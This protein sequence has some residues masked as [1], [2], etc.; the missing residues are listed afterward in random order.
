MA[1]EFK[2]KNG[3]FSEGSS[4]V[5]GSLNV[6][7][8]ITGSLQGTA[9]FATTAGSTTA[10]AGTT[11]YV[12][13]FTSGTTIGN[14]QIFDNG[15]NVGIGTTSPTYKLDV[16][17][18]TLINSSIS[19]QG[20][21][22]I[23]PLAPPPAITGY[24]LSAGSSLGVGNYY[25]F[26]T[27]VT[28]IGET[29]AGTTLIVT[30]TPGSTTVNL[31]G[32]PISSDARVTAR[33]LYRTKLGGTSDNQ[34]LLAT[35]NNNTTTTYTDSIADAS[36]TGLGLQYYKINTTSR[37]IT[38]SGI[39]SMFLD[40]N[41]TAIGR[42][43]G[44]AL[45][46]ANATAVR[47]VLVGTL[48]GQNITTGT[49]NVIVGVAGASLTSGNSNSIL[50]D[51]ALYNASTGNNN[52]AVGSQVGRYLTVGNNNV[53]VGNNAASLLNDG[54]TQFT[55]PTLGVYIG[56]N[57]R[58]SSTTETNAIVI[59][60]GALGLGSNTVVL[61]NDSIVTT[62]LKGNVG[63]G[64]T[65]P[66]ARLHV[67][68]QG[69][70]STDI[71]FRVRN[72]ANTFD[73]IRAQGNGSVFIGLG[74]GNVNTGNGNTAFGVQALFSNTTGV[75][76]TAFGNGALLANTTA[77]RN[78]AFGYDNLRNNTTGYE[79]TSIGNEALRANS[80]GYRNTADGFQALFSNTTGHS[81]T[82]NGAY[83]LQNNTTGNENTV[84]GLGALVFNTT[85]NNNIANGSN[86]GRLI[87]N[88]S[89]LTITNN[90]VFLGAGT[91][92]LADNQTNQIVIGHNAIG[93]GSNSVVL[94][95]DLITLTALKGNVGIGTTSPTARLH[96]QA[97]GALSTDIAF[98]VRNSAGTLDIIRA[99]G[100][101]SVFVGQGAGNVNTGTNNTAH[102]INALRSNTTGGNN[103][104]NGVQSLLDNTTGN[105]NTA[106]G[107][108]ALRSN[109]TGGNN[110]A[111]GASAGRYIADGITA[112]TITNNSVYLG[113]GTRAQDNNQTNQIVIGHNAIGNGSNTVTL[114]NTSIVKT[115]LRGTLNAANL[116]TSP[117]GLVTGD[118]WNNLGILTIV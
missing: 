108:F 65:S 37:H 111:N 102:G 110:T 79:N 27:Y 77:I 118:I 61:G 105:N 6:S 18:T 30:T 1:N 116:P 42:N 46:A 98:R 75:N 11:N 36:L 5:T 80:T 91:R 8:G 99:Q 60:N 47:T 22:N 53:M 103:T 71:G 87:A 20:A 70:L 32:I 113:V 106:N 73:I 78:T 2:I 90:S 15:T 63:I 109:T 57:V 89:N 31:T 96:V 114:G 17:G 107:I 25:Y 13:K 66:T 54:V 58:G 62:A 85:G 44:S 74:A 51:L 23:N 24:T 12:S 19:T 3:F 9:S 93:L 64:T 41:L 34:W 21:F 55:S 10:V 88:G 48:A 40:T 100:D 67:Q 94:G 76:N 29:S 33:K 104:A 39:Q 43:A 26:A 86:A 45:I 56:A 16:H 101:G 35:I 4:N 14:S 49:A 59:G 115:I 112:N 81:N 38:V 28:S 117:V 82:A 97:P 69:A 83:A 50:G 52:T 84:N 7:A 95:N 68:A 92:A 72:S